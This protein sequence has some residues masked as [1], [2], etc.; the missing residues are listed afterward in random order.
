[1]PTFSNDASAIA[2]FSGRPVR[3][4]VAR[5]FFQSDQQ[6][7]RLADFVHLVQCKGA[8]QLVWFLPNPRSYL[9]TPEQLS[10][11]L[12]LRPRVRRP[13]GVIYDVRPR[14]PAVGKCA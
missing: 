5:T 9:Y 4:S 7:G 8:V 1:M 3:P 6:T 13:D 14:R 11:Q 2:L 10:K 12:Q